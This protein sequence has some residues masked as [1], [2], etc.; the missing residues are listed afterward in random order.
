M[1][2]KAFFFI[3]LNCIFLFVNIFD[4]TVF[5]QTRNIVNTSVMLIDTVPC[6]KILQDLRIVGNKLY[7]TYEEPNSWGQMIFCS[8]DI[9][10]KNN[11]LLRRRVYFKKDNGS[12]GIF[13][14]ITFWDD[15]YNL[16]VVERDDPHIY[17]VLSDSLCK[18]DNALITE[19][20]HVPYEMALNVRQAFYKSKD[21]YYFIGRQPLNGCCGIYH[22]CNTDNQVYIKEIK[23]IV[24]NEKNTSWVANQGRFEYNRNCGAYAYLF[25]PG[26]QFFNFTN[27]TQTTFTVKTLHNGSSAELSEE[28]IYE[29][30][31]IYFNYIASTE[32]YLYAL[33]WG[34]MLKDMNDRHKKGLAVTKILK[35]DWDGKL[36]EVYSVNKRLQAISVSEDN[37]KVVGYDGKD[38]L[39]MDIK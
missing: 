18:T 20:S 21:E 11:S 32:Q 36:C 38:F 31:C 7:I 6:I 24:F 1:C 29:N 3:L 35:Y 16:F 34:A 27:N 23:K 13:F 12:Y 17:M 15:K 8:Y 2:R 39:M 5:A 25:F 9:D 10:Y 30:S 4:V 19:T 28:D 22:S 26:I 14:P 37:K 33:Y